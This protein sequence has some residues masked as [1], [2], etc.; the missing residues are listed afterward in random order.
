MRFRWYLTG[1]AID[2]Y[3]ALMRCG[4]RADAREELGVVCDGARLVHAAGE[5][6]D[7]AAIYVSSIRIAGRTRRFELYVTEY[8][9]PEGPLPQ[10][11]RVRLKDRG[12]RPR[13]EQENRPL[14]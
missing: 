5:K 13:R 9:R 2:E 7:T 8:P 11:V 12:K 3:R 6:N 10:L 4:T 1:T 14:P